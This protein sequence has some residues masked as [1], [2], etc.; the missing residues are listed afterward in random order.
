MSLEK[1]TVEPREVPQ[2]EVHIAA[3]C[4]MTV[5]QQ[6]IRLVANALTGSY[7]VVLPPVGPAQGKFYSFVMRTGSAGWTVTLTDDDDSE[8][9]LADITFNAKC[10]RA[11]LFSDGHCWLALGS[12]LTL[13]GT[14]APPT[15]PAPTTPA[16]TTIIPGP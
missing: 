1:T 4:H 8:C 9:W 15:T 3:A 10:D 6:R 5:H 2:K 12:S 7:V 16:P 13:T 11:V 14:T